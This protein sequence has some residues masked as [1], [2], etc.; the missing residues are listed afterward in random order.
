MLRTVTERRLTVAPVRLGNDKGSIF[1][2]VNNFL[3]K[4]K[5]A[6]GNTK[7]PTRPPINTSTNACRE[8]LRRA[9]PIASTLSVKHFDAMPSVPPSLFSR[10]SAAARTP[11]FRP[12]SHIRGYDH[13][14]RKYA[15]NFLAQHPLCVRCLSLD[16]TTLAT[17]VDH[18]IPVTE[19]GQSDPNFWRRENHQP[20]CV[21]CHAK[22]TAQDRAQGLT[23]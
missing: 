14:W 19:A 13:R 1:A 15:K 21:R 11:D 8:P 16:R 6:P 12:D 10:P 18:I 23:R 17:C 22:K 7:N 20:L 4:K 2:A 9:K 5:A 3:T